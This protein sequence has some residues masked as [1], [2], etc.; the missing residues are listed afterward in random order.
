MT[1]NNHPCQVRRLEGYLKG[2]I[3][4]TIL[5]TDAPEQGTKYLAHFHPE[6]EAAPLSSEEVLTHYANRWPIETF[7]RNAKQ[8]LGFNHY[9]LR[10]T[11]GIKRYLEVLLLAYTVIENRR[12]L[13]ALKDPDQPPPTLGEVCRVEQSESLAGFVIWVYDQ[14]QR[15]IPV[16]TIC[17]RLAG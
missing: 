12:G 1:V 3:K 13:L 11:A 5:I 9:R 17:R 2:G 8:L 14:F 15:G 10:S 6:D 4:A 7:H 16:E